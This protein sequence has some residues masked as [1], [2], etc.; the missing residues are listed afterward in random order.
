MGC[1]PGQHLDFNNECV[2]CRA[3]DQVWCP[4]VRMCKGSCPTTGK[5]SCPGDEVLREGECLCP[6]PRMERDDSG[7]CRCSHSQLEY[8]EDANECLCKDRSKMWRLFDEEC[9][10]GPDWI[11]EPHNQALCGEGTFNVPI[12]NNDRSVSCGTCHESCIGGCDSVTGFC[13]TGCPSA[14]YMNWGQECFC[15]DGTVD[16]RGECVAPTVC[17]AGEYRNADNGCSKGTIRNCVD[18]EDGTGAC[19]TCATSY[20]LIG[21]E[22]QKCPAGAV[23]YGNPERPSG[24]VVPVAGQNLL[25]IPSS[26]HG[27]DWRDWGVVSPIRDQMSCGSCWT[28]QAAAVIE[29]TYAVKYGPLIPVSEQQMLDCAPSSGC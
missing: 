11:F 23:S 2:T 25:S 19:E 14:S 27:V 1:Q 24:C 20:T 6:D 16:I 7:Q 28:F 10:N 26:V 3:V 8:D 12:D 21:N 9:V 22:C 15:P 5:T 4:D 18:F 29:S 13:S 17:S